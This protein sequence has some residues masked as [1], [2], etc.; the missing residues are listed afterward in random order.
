L[1][2]GGVIGSCEASFKVFGI[3]QELIG[4]QSECSLQLIGIEIAER[5]GFRKNEIGDVALAGHDFLDSLIDSAG[6]HEAM[7]NDCFVLTNSPRA[8][9]CLIFYRRVPPAVIQDDV[10]GIGE[11]EAGAACLQ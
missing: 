3:G 1:P 2:D 10:V 6:T 5:T 8:V 9:A 4:A 7:R 11:I